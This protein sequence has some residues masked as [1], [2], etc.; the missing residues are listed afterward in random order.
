MGRIRIWQACVLLAMAQVPHFSCA[1]SGPAQAS[2][3]THAPATLSPA[4]EKLA[5][6]ATN[7]DA[8]AQYELA[9][10]YRNGDGVP[11]SLETAMLWLT[12]AAKQGHIPAQATL[13]TSYLVGEGATKDVPTAIQWLTKAAQHGNPLA[14]TNLGALYLNGDGAPQD[15][16]LALFWLEKA[17]SQGSSLAQYSLGKMYQKGYGVRTDETVAAQWFN[18]ALQQNYLPAR[19]A[20]AELSGGGSAGKSPPAPAAFASVTPS[21]TANVAASETAATEREAIAGTIQAWAAAWSN[22]KVDDYLGF[23]ADSFVPASGESRDAWAAQR[24]A[25]VS[26]RKRISVSITSPEIEVRG[27]SASAVFQ[28]KYVS[29]NLTETSTKKMIWVRQGNDWKIQQ[30]ISEKPVKSGR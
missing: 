28:Q 8:E 4:L 13:G 12:M 27:P 6:A 25:R 30:E 17:A 5:N 1:Q 3:P 16:R 24:R 9:R 21:R 19:Q 29:D 26:G 23:Y 2:G 14:Q 10:R 22:K 20:L 18:K 7:G 11:R 15:F